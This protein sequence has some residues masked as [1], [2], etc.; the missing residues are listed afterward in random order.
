MHIGTRAIH[1]LYRCERS[2]ER[3]KILKC[4]YVDQAIAR[5]CMGFQAFRRFM[6]HLIDNSMYRSHDCLLA[7]L[8]QSLHSIQSELDLCI[9]QSRDLAAKTGQD[10]YH[11]A[12]M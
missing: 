9:S 3:E 6:Q 4:S 2:V 5:G 11:L 1:P 8:V 7:L 10:G 12:A